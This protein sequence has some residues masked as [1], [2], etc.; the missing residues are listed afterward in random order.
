MSNRRK[1]PVPLI[2]WSKRK[3]L[4]DS[5]W[6]GRREGKE[7]LNREEICE[8]SASGSMLKSLGLNYK[9]I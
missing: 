7:Y 1:V 3:I 2:Y 5:A 8:G 9:K 4:S 6:A